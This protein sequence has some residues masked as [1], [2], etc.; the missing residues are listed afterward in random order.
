M[1]NNILL[2]IAVVTILLAPLIINQLSYG[3]KSSWSEKVKNCTDIYQ[4]EYDLDGYYECWA[5]INKG[6]E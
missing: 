3:D 1:N 6:L 2:L 5:E 4:N